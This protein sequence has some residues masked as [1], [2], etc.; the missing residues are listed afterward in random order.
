MNLSTAPHA[1]ASLA[2]RGDVPHG[3]Q[4]RPYECVS[5]TLNVHGVEGV[6]VIDASVMPN[7]V[8]AN[9]NAPTMALADCGLSQLLSVAAGAH[10]APN[11]SKISADA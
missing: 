7:I 1:S 11:G 4:R 3:S 2:S 9:A 8:I 6:R 5:E 10:L